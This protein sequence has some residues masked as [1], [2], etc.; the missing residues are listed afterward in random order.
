MPDRAR[1]R[2]H[3][4]AL[5]EPPPAQAAPLAGAG[6]YRGYAELVDRWLHAAEHGARVR[7]IGAS[8]EGAPLVALELGPEIAPASTVILAGLHPLEW[9]GVEVLLALLADLAAQ[10]PVQRCVTFIPLVNVDG[11]R[12]VEADLRAGRR[13]WRRYNSRGVDLNRNWPAFFRAR[14]GWLGGR[15]GPAPLSE[16]ETAAVLAALD[17]LH[18]RAPIDVAVSL[19]CF[20]R[21]VLVP[22]GG[23]WQPPE[24][25]DHLHAAASAVAGR[26]VRR[27]RVRQVSRWLPGFFA[28]GVEIDTL[29]QRYGAQALLIECGGGGLAPGRPATWS[30]PFCW[31]NP[32]DPG[33]EIHA[34]RAALAPLVRGHAGRE[35]RAELTR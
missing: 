7:I 10:P 17:R 28:R 6:P 26:L 13:R 9:I 15:S 27:Y 8:V 35:D 1:L 34:L 14:P 5:P 29:H 33:P 3:R 31:Y 24:R 22:Y 21:M 25:A 11:Y 16:P 19:H 23:R 12:R 18:G 20:G 32:A 2:S 30:Q 4:L